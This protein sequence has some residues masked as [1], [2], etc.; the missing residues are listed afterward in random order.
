MRPKLEAIPF[1]R[2][3]VPERMTT[4]EGRQK[5]CQCM[6]NLIE[7]SGQE[8]KA[9]IPE[10]L[11]RPET[12][13]KMCQLSTEGE[14]CIAQCTDS[15]KKE[16]ARK[17]LDLFK[18]GCN[19]EFKSKIRCVIDVKKTPSQECQRKC[20]PVVTPLKNFISERERDP[21]NMVLPTKEVLESGCKFINCR[22]SCRKTDIVNKCQESGFEQAKKWWSTVA[23]STKVLFEK[24]GGDMNTWPDVCKSERIGE[25]QN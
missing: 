11:G 3:M 25:F 14:Q 9:K 10:E 20:N 18:L 12:L 2:G 16:T 17:L 5:M 22:L 8:I 19:E 6:K 1:L 7:E 15:P 24:V 13:T 21:N 23:E 4:Q